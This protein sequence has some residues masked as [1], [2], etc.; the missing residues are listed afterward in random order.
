[1]RNKHEKAYHF[2]KNIF[3]FIQLFNRSLWT[4]YTKILDSLLDIKS[5]FKK[6]YQKKKKEYQLSELKKKIRIPGLKIRNTAPLSLNPFN[7]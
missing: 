1:M 7:L 5:P 3:D 4:I 6:E 2:I